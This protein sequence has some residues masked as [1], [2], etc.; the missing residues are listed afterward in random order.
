MTTYYMNPWTGSVDTKENWEDDGW[1]QDNSFLVE[2][3][4]DDNG[5]WVEVE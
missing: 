3:K 1:D 5:D 2:V 4:K